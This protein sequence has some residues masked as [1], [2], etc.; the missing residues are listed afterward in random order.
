MN[1][2]RVNVESE[3]EGKCKRKKMEMMGIG[4]AAGKVEGLSL[5]LLVV[6]KARATLIRPGE[7]K[8]GGIWWGRAARLVGASS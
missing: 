8:V 1:S 4:K 3:G 5:A 2:L 7:W 6:S